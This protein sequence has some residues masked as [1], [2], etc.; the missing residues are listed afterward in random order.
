MPHYMFR[1]SYSAEG[2][3]GVISEG[4]TARR[5]AAKA[6]AE[7]MGGRLEALYFSFGEDDVIGIIELPDNESMA[8]LAMEV[9]SSGEISTS[10]TV[11]LTP[12]EIDGARE[13]H[14]GFRAPGR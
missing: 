12:E 10:T 11:L 6:A 13:K 1:A 14:S 9:A 5:D 8:A 2:I 3:A 7:A 4:G